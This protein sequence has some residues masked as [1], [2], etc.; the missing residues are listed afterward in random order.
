MTDWLPQVR[1][2]GESD[3]AWTAFIKYRDDGP[4]HRSLARVATAIVA[5]GETTEQPR[6]FRTVS[7]QIEEWSSKHHWRERVEAWDAEL[8][9]VRRTTQ[10]EAVAEMAERHAISRSRHSTL[11]CDP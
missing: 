11:R 8:D 7:R 6:S 4:E 1:A 3:R 9:L 2:P 10:K 5:D